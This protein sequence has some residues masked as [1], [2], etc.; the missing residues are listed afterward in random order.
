VGEVEILE[1]RPISRDR[2]TG[3]AQ[4]PAQEGAIRIGNGAV[5]EAGATGQRRAAGETAVFVTLA[6][7]GKLLIAADEEESGGD[8][9]GMYHEGIAPTADVRLAEKERN[10]VYLGEGQVRQGAADLPRG[11]DDDFVIGKAG[12]IVSVTNEAGKVFADKP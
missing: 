3:F 6:G 10:T 2:D 1:A 4:P 8:N 7:A 11:Q 9:V 12:F 5:D